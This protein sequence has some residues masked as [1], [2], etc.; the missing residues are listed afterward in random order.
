MS[1]TDRQ[2]IALLRDN[3]RM[4]VTELAQRLRVSRATVQ[5]RIDK[6]EQS[7]VIIGYTVRLKPEAEGHRIRAWM[8]IAVEGNKAQAVLQALRGEPHVY[9]LHSTNGRW[10]IVTELRADSLEQFDRVLG[11]IRLI[12]GIAATET[13][14]L[15]STHKV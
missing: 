1:D 6:L 11:R 9:A 5:N 14:L 7:G 3:A 13:S 10:D 2:L 15:L 4:S 8:G 12:P